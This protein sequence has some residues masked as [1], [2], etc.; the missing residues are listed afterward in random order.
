FSRYG[1]NDSNLTERFSDVMRMPELAPGAANYQSLDLARYMDRPGAGRQG[2]F[3]LRIEAWDTE[4]NQPVY[5][6]SGGSTNDTRL[7]VV[8]DLGMIAK[9]SVDGTQDVFVQSIAT[10]RPVAGVTVQ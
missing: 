9:R 8:T 1:F 10:G 7:V 2:I 6:G 5:D 3:L 4:R